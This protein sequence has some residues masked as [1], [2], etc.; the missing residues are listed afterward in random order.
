[1]DQRGAGPAT[2]HRRSVVAG[3]AAAGLFAPAVVAQ[4]EPGAEGL[5]VNS[6]TR[7]AANVRVNGRRA[8]FVLDTGAERT[9][10]SA[11]LA[12][13]L[14]L[15]AGPE[16]IVHG[17]TAARA[18]PSVI[19]PRLLFGGRSFSG[20]VAPVFD[21]SSLAADGL[22]GLDVLSRFR[23]EMDLVRRRVLI[24][25][26]GDGVSTIV[27]S[28][29]LVISDRVRSGR[30]GQLILLNV[31]VQGR[32]V[33]AF[34]D[35]GAQYS[36]GNPALLAAVNRSTEAG[37]IDVFGVT[38]QTLRARLGRVDDLRIDGKDLGATPLL[39]ADLHA[40]E[41]LGLNDRPAILLGADILYRFQRVTL[42]YGRGRVA[43]GR[44]RPAF[45]P[46]PARGQ[47]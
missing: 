39:F 32:V 12:Q 31:L 47:A 19:L 37:L 34:V 17:V 41:A 46:P 35:S 6:L 26:S 14:E 22:V 21:R 1:M 28:T 16:M 30:F 13:S 23:L 18:V 9:A 11:D 24:H 29:R 33:E 27:P 8:V 20:I 42:D 7:M 38:G 36:I 45:A 10:I 43:F 5:S 25:S 15:P 40:F 4:T 44:V 2:I 3:L